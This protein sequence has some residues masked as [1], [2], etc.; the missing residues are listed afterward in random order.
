MDGVLQVYTE[1]DEIST[2]EIATG[3]GGAARGWVR[4]T[5]S[6]L[7]S[8]SDLACRA[9]SCRANRPNTV[10]PLP[11]MAAP[12]APAWI[13]VFLMASICRR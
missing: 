1:L 3:G 10:G 4:K 6:W 12:R 11:L 13:M 5:S 2:E 8:S 7:A 9:K